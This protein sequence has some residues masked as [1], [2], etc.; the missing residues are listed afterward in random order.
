MNI[1]TEIMRINYGIKDSRDYLNNLSGTLSS[2]RKN[3]TKINGKLVTFEKKVT[4][5]SKLGDLMEEFMGGPI[6]EDL[7]GI[8]I[9]DK[10]TVMDDSDYIKSVSAAIKNKSGLKRLLALVKIIKKLA[11]YIDSLESKRI[12][13][14]SGIRM[15]SPSPEK[16]LYKDKIKIVENS[17][18][19]F[20]KRKMILR[21]RFDKEL[22]RHK[23]LIDRLVTELD[24]IS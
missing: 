4:E 9:D 18:N 21:N 24:L 8:I 5:L 1:S 7:Q 16:N 12:K 13:M 3:L 11:A 23:G 17:I 6:H 14:N 15:M 10:I 2:I 19:I 22:K 20:Y